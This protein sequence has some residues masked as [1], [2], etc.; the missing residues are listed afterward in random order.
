MQPTVDIISLLRRKAGTFPAREQRVA[1]YV[2]D[3]LQDVTTIAL[4]DLAQKVGVS[5]P[6][7][8]R[9]C[10]TLGCDGFRDFKIRLAQNLA[11]SMQ[12]LAP[13]D[14]ADDTTAADVLSNHVLGVIVD[15]L[16]LLREQLSSTEI[17]KAADILANARQIAFMGVGGGSTTVAFDAANRFFRLGI[18]AQAQSDGYLQRMLASTF[19][20]EDVLFAISTSGRPTELIHSAAIARQY[21]AKVISMTHPQS[22]LAAESDLVIGIDMPENP[23]IYKPTATRHVFLATIDI[24]ATAVARRTPDRTLEKLRRIRSSL[25]TL[26]P[27]TGRQPI[28]D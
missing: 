20:E 7:V 25:L 6:T 10:R 27:P 2:Q 15:N 12:Y 16:R 24:I 4:S 9:F 5:E 21:G 1:D 26:N 23:D 14:L 22:P 11:V 13:E 3:H 28:G 19:G 17:D 8:I 18:P